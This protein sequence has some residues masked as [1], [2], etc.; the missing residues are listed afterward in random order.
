LL[1]EDEK[2]LQ[3]KTKLPVL[4]RQFYQVWRQKMDGVRKKILI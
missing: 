4:E 2:E 3:I 1:Q